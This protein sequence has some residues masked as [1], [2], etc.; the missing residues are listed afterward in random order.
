MLWPATGPSGALIFL[1]NEPSTRAG[2]GSGDTAVKPA[3]K[4]HTG[5]DDDRETPALRLHESVT[6]HLFDTRGEREYNARHLRS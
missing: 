1:A 5:S 6:D 3:N 4:P 2:T